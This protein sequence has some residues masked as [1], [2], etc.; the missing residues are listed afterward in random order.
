M[1]TGKQT[2]YGELAT[3]VESLPMLVRE[4]R[5]RKGLSLREAAKE[6]G[7]SF[8]TLTRFEHGETGWNARLLA[9]LLRWLGTP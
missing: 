1:S 3:I 6:I 8:S 5:R 2:T 9:D 7:C 4:H